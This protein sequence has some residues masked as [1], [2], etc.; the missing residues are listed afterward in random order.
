SPEAAALGA[1]K[2]LTHNMVQAIELN[3]VRRGYDPRDFALVAFGG[4]GP[5]FARDI[6]RGLGVPRGVGAPAPG[7]TSAFGL[8]ATDVSYE[9]GRTVASYVNRINLDELAALYRSIEN[10]LLGQL[11]A[12]G[13]PVERIRLMRFADCRYRGQGYELRT[14]ARSGA[15]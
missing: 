11:A 3:S 4:G 2:I 14:A 10:E 13:F 15:I 12:D 6:A 8:L 7:L 1:I 9:F 5:M